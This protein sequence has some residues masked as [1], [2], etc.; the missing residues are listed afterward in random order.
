[1]A[2]KDCSDCGHQCSTKAFA[3]PE[4]GRLI[5]ARGWWVATIG[6]GVILSAFISFLLSFA[7]L[8]VM[9]ALFGNLSMFGF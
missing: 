6:W 3:C 4:C 8:F 2:L 7:F 1:M 9:Y 5:S